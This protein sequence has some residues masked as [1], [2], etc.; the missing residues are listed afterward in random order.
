MKSTCEQI[1][2]ARGFRSFGHSIRV[3]LCAGLCVGRWYVLSW[4]L[5]RRLIVRR[6]SYPHAWCIAAEFNRPVSLPPLF[7]FERETRNRTAA[8]GG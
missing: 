2:Q 4:L 8:E 7:E 5:W 1:Q 3:S 6:G